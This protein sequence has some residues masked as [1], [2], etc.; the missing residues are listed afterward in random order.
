MMIQD[1]YPNGRQFM[2]RLLW[3]MGLDVRSCHVDDSDLK[4]PLS[5]VFL[6]F[7]LAIM[8]LLSISFLSNLAGA[9]DVKMIP[10]LAAGAAYDDNITFSSIEKVSSSILTVSPGLEVDYQT[11]LSSFSL[12]A[13]LDILNYQQESDL[14]RTNQYYRLSGDHRIKERWD[15]TADFKYYRD[16]TLNT[17]LQE[18]GRVIDRVERDFLEAG[19]D[20]SYNVTNISTITAGYIF[21]NANYEDD[22]Y[23][24]YDN[25]QAKLY[26][27]H[28]LKSQV[29]SLSIGPS[30]YHRR[31]DF[32]DVDSLA[33]DIAW[34]RDWSSITNSLASIGAR[35]TNVKQNDGTEGD[36]WGAKALVTLTSQGLASTTTFRYSHDL[37]TTVDGEDVNV[38]NFYL[39]YRRSI[40]ERFGA[41]FNGRLVFS[42]KLLDTD[43]DINDER[44]Y[45]LEPRLFYQLTEN[46]DLSLRYRYQNNVEVLDEGDQTRER[47]IVW[48]QLSYGLPILM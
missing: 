4:K 45:W 42:Y 19:G 21:R 11:L 44:Y 23:S 34:K 14:N 8:L 48:L 22:V 41:G 12:K 16:T 30:Y 20:V 33:L 1:K 47:N 27:S 37:R 39:T 9:A 40:T 17:Y 28:R 32:N 13:D 10:K 3:G 35:Y 46:F 18:T 24:D 15:T 2:K 29:D 31:N 36:K 38:D 43:S 25:H 6:V 26:Y 7:F 5:K